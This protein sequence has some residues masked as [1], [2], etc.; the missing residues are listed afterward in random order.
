MTYIQD[1]VQQ[2]DDKR[3]TQIVERTN[4]NGGYLVIE[5][6][7]RSQ[8][9]TLIHM[10]TCV[11]SLTF[12]EAS[13]DS[14]DHASLFRQQL[15]T[16]DNDDSQTSRTGCRYIETSIRRCNGNLS[17][18]GTNDGGS[19]ETIL[20]TPKG[21]WPSCCCCSLSTTFEHSKHCCTYSYYG[22]KEHDCNRR[23]SKE[24]LCKITD[25]GETKKN[26]LSEDDTLWSCTVHR[27]CR[28]ATRN[29]DSCV[30]AMENIRSHTDWTQTTLVPVS[31][32]ADLEPAVRG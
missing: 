21:E 30:G 4:E 24:S 17:V 2:E 3:I 27:L 10:W 6:D 16:R 25:D 11:H 31:N 12:P 9:E 7:E 22:C 19:L 15:L 18:R 20:G 8:R 29:D 28:F 32:I 5:L 1:L 26:V 13:L 14:N 23:T